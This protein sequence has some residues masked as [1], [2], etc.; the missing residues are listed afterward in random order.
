MTTPP[1]NQ[2]S[3]AHAKEKRDGGVCCGGHHAGGCG[4]DH[5]HGG[6][7]HAAHAASGAASGGAEIAVEY[8]GVSF[9]YRNR[10]AADPGESRLALENVS[11]RV[12]AGQRLGILGPNGGGKSTLL[13]LTLGLL[14]AHEGEIRIFGRAPREARRER[15]V[16]YVPQRVEAELSFPITARQVVEMSATVGLPAWRGIDASTREHCRSMIELVDAAAFA[17]APVGRLS[18]GQ[19]QRIMIARALAA[20]PRVLLLDEPTVGIDVSGQKRFADLLVRLHDALGLTILV[21]SH[22]IRTVASGCDMIA[23]LSRTLHA[24]VAPEGLTPGVLAD[25][26]RHDVAAIFG[27]LHVHAHPADACP[28]PHG[29]GSG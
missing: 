25:V 8:R 1:D 11:L 9:A 18:G 3:A 22:D 5:A 26:F 2:G 23:C 16:G 29:R 15:L 27:E 7:A 10:R 4:H 13:K 19:L 12:A 21:V 17:D 14:D 24:H 6:H 20:R 28:L